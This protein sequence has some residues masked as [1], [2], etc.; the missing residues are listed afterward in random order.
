MKQK[1]TEVT[2]KEI[3]RQEVT[4]ETN[5]E[6]LAASGL[7][8]LRCFRLLLLKN[9]LSDLCVLLCFFAFFAPFRGYSIPSV[10]PQP[11]PRSNR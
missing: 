3:F 1:N 6:S 11:F 4:K 10:W 5:D 8:T 2:K 7:F 9:R